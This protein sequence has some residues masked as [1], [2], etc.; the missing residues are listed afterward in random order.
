MRVEMKAVC[1]AL[2]KAALRVDYSV[3]TKAESWVESWALM[4]AVKTVDYSAMMMAVS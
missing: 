3:V 4:M 2:Q 1:S